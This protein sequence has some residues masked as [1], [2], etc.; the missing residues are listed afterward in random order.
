MSLYDFVMANGIKSPPGAIVVDGVITRYWPAAGAGKIILLR[1]GERS[2]VG[3]DFH[4]A[5]VFTETRLP[6]G[7]KEGDPVEVAFDLQ[8]N[9][10]IHFEVRRSHLPE[11]RVVSS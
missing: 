3:I 1:H 9:S 8:S 11:P 6:R 7:P 10:G 2:D 5:C 4:L